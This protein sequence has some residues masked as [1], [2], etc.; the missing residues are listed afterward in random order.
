MTADAVFNEAI[1]GLAWAPSLGVGHYPVAE[2]DEPY[3]NGGAQAYWEK[4]AGYAETPLGVALTDTRV[5]L[6]REHTKGPVVDVG[7]GCGQ[8]VEAMRAAGSDAYGC[9]VNPVAVAWLNHRGLWRSPWEQEVDA[10]TFWDVLEHIPDPATMLAGVRTWAF[11][12]TPV[13]ESAEAVLESRH[14]RPNEHRWYWTAD[15]LCRWM[16]AQGFGCVLRD[17][18]ETDLGR[19][20][21]G[22][23]VFRRSA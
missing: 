17:R 21:I 14:F 12:A 22:T 23:F 16:G 1:S 6:V 8:F 2:R 9:D 13:F 18:R 11:V 4:Y 19:E 15:G 20:G 10:V 7:I 3:R 5:T